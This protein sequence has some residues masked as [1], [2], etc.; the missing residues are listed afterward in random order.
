MGKLYVVG[1]GPGDYS[2]LTPMAE[3]AI[4]TSDS[5]CGYTTYI[6]II[7]DIIPEGKEIYMSGMK[8]EVQRAKKALEFAAEGKTVSLVCGGDASLYSLA[9]LVQEMDDGKSEIII[10][11][12][13]TAGLAA[14]AKL[15]GV[16]ADDLAVISMSDLLT[17]WEIIEK[18]IDAVNLGDFVCAVYNPKSTK[19]VTQLPY[20]LN[21]FLEFRGDLVVGTVKN[22][23]RETEEIK[24]SNISNFDYDFVDMSSVVIVGC[25]KTILKNGKMITPR[26][27]TVK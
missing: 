13:I 5:I 10:V 12:G 21:K 18:R 19:R 9:S 14:A 23:F 11:P 26:G 7:K 4:K 20:T 3:N 16:V 2:L 1:I 25:R 8:G 27:Y 6:E 22:C 15:G 17:P 24:I